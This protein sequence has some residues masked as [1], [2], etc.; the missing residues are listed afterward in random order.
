MQVLHEGSI[1]WTNSAFSHKNYPYGIDA[2]TTAVPAAA[3]PSDPTSPDTPGANALSSDTSQGKALNT[4]ENVRSFFG[5]QFPG[6]QE[7]LASDEERAAAQKRKNLAAQRPLSSQAKVL[8]EIDQFPPESS[9]NEILGEKKQR[10]F[11][12]MMEDLKNAG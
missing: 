7:A 3:N 9:P 10:S 6:I 4:K 1:G 2:G 8:T 5:S 11:A 12:Q